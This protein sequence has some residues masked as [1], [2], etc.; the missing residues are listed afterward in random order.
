MKIRR[1]EQSSRDASSSSS[2]ERRAKRRRRQSVTGIHGLRSV[3]P[4]SG[5]TSGFHLK[6]PPRIALDGS[7]LACSSPSLSARTHHRPH[8]PPA[9]AHSASE[10][11]C[12][13]AG[14]RAL[15]CLCVCVYLVAW[16]VAATIG[17]ACSLSRIQSLIRTALDGL[18]VSL[19]QREIPCLYSVMVKPWERR[20]NRAGCES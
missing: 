3:C 17:A 7:L 1:S 11:E 4:Q 8:L 16:D 9:G 6:R 13:R 19:A 10:R 20:Q 14:P 12:G 15:L 18:G 5:F 2:D